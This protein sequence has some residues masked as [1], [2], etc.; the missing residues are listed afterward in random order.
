MRIEIIPNFVSNTELTELN[1]WA[2]LGVQNKWLDEGNIAGGKTT[3]RLTSRL[4]PER[5]EY[6]Q[7]VLD[8][9]EKVR[10]FMGIDGYSI[11]NGH[12]RDGVVVSYTLPG[13][14]VFKHKDPAIAEGLAILRC[15]IVTQKADTGG[16]L[17]VGDALVNAGVGDLHCYLA[18]EH[19][20]FVTT[21]EGNTP[22]ILWIF[23]ALVPADDWNSGKIKVT[24]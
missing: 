23:G 2:N 3:T 12:G 1:A 9:S 17:Y 21:V 22:R 15:N 13:G 14:D 6:P 10:S 19:E 11:V 16:E 20:H 5:Y 4:Y 18:S 8:L 24:V 7:F